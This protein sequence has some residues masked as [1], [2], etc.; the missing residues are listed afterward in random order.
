MKKVKRIVFVHNDGEKTVWTPKSGRDKQVG[1]HLCEA[2]Q[3]MAKYG[4]CNSI[5]WGI[6]A[7]RENRSSI[8]AVGSQKKLFMLAGGLL[9]I[10][11]QTREDEEDEE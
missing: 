1:E 9:D 6:L 2:L 7:R 8:C 10:L 5:I 4:G 3:H 11:G